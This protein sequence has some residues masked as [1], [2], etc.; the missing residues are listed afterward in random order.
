MRSLRLGNVT[1]ENIHAGVLP[2]TA[3]PLLGQAFLERFK[4][5]SIDTVKRELLLGEKITPL[6]AG[7][8]DQIVPMS[9]RR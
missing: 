9:P 3:Y 1:V 4:G 5:W 6:V 8:G 7:A 2:A